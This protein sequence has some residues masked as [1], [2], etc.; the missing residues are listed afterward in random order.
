MTDQIQVAKLAEDVADGQIIDWAAAESGASGEWDRAVIRRLKRISQVAVLHRGPTEPRPVRVS[1]S[2]ASARPDSASH[3]D[4]HSAPRWGHLRLLAKIGQ[5]AYGEVYRAWDTALDC[6]VALKLLYA[7]PSSAAETSSSVPEG[8]LLARVRHPNVVTVYGADRIDGRVGLWMELIDGQTLDQLLAARG[9]LSATDATNIGLDLCRALGAVHRAG[10][11]HRD[12][13]AQNVMRDANGRTVLM[14]F[15]AGRE[16]AGEISIDNWAG[17]PLYLAPEIFA[18]TP[19]SASSDIYALGV[20]LYHLVTNGYPVDGQNVQ[21]VAATHR[22]GAQQPLRLAQPDLPQGFVAVIDRALAPNPAERFASAGAFEAVLAGTLAPAAAPPL[23]ARH[24][25]RII[26]G[27]AVAATVVVGAAS[28]VAW[29]RTHADPQPLTG[30]PHDDVL[31]GVFDNRTGSP[32][33]DGVIEAGLARELSNSEFVTPAPQQRIDDALRLMAKPVDT[34]LGPAVAREVCLRDGGIRTFVAGELDRRGDRYHLAASLFDATS[35]QLVRTAEAEAATADALPSAVR[36]L[37]DR[38]RVDLG[39]PAKTVRQ[40]A[41]ALEKVTT[42]SLQA[43]RLLSGGLRAFNDGRLPAAE[44]EFK[45]ALALDPNF[46]SAHIWLAWTRL[47]LGSPPQDY[48]SSAKRAMDL[49]TSVSDHEREWIAGSYYQMTGRNDQAIAAYETLLARHPDDYWALN[50]LDNLY[51]GNGDR[52]RASLDLE[53]RLADAL[54]L[55]L[56]VQATTAFQFLHVEGP[57]AALPRVARAR[58]LMS[59][60]SNDTDVQSRQAKLAILLFPAHDLWTKG[61]AADAARIL[62]DTSRQPEFQVTNP[63]IMNLIGLMRLELGQ[64][65]LA[66]AA[67]NHMSAGRGLTLSEVALARGDRTGMAAQLSGIPEGDFPVISL[68]LRAGLVDAAA[69]MLPRIAARQPTDRADATWSADEIEEARGNTTRITRSLAAGSP[70]TNWISGSIRTFLYSETLA[71]AAARMGDRPA[72]IKVLETA[73][74]LDSRA[75]GILN[76]SGFYWMRNQK[77]LADLYRADGQV[78]GA[79][80]IERDLLA[81]LAVADP[82]YPLLVALKQRAGQ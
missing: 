21:E 31:I 8:R 70:W 14:D 6:D 10:L 47:N 60:R 61:R 18:G 54:P 20:L 51:I 59:T 3:P 27:W 12:L 28:A 17:T 74:P 24:R 9:P 13:K 67:F 35:G 23:T 30:Q 79:R 15:G 81:R 36:A 43:V 62:D 4:P 80:T 57:D 55:N 56:R 68:M 37:S 75:Y 58:Q 16:S 72:A 82:D 33:L 22:A 1:A 32:S 26:A 49:A 78:A 48:E 64:V 53:R 25:A 42:P 11:V 77:L 45:A 63:S 52:P 34:P 71:L 65:H 50:N 19:A 46:A 7:R 2:T 5:G 69:R 76:A 40:T 73:A 39:E 38:L 29:R 66:E 41:Q 44:A